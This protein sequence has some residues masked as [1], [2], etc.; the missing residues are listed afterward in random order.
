MDSLAIGF[1]VGLAFV[2]VVFIVLTI[3]LYK[4]NKSLKQRNEADAK[5]A[6]ELVKEAQFKAD[7]LL[8]EAKEEGQ[9]NANALIASAKK[10]YEKSN[11]DLEERKNAIVQ[12]EAKLDQKEASLDKR[13]DAIINRETVID[14]QKDELN[15]RSEALAI[16]EKEAQDKLESVLNELQ[17]VANRTRDQAKD[18]LRKRVEE[19]ERK[20]IAL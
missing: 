18:E 5:K 19:K 13:E 7:A 14:K 8:Q 2:A 17:K 10:E 16:K 6:E 20:R 11:A 1:L 9:K 12:K 4:K 15:Q 3:L